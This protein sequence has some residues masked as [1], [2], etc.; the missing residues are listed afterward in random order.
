MSFAIWVRWD[1]L[2]TWSRI[3]DFGGGDSVVNIILSNVSTGR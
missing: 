1:S 3:F 2:K